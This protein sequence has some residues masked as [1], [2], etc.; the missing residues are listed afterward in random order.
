MNCPFCQHVDTKVNDSR[1]DSGGRSIRRRREC[2]ACGRRWRTLERI[3]DEMPLV[4]K[5]NQTYQ[6]FNR[7]KLLTSMTVSCGKRP[8]SISQIE[9]AAAEIEWGILESGCESVS[10]T[11]LGEMVMHHLRMLDEI[12]Y[13]RYAS[14]YRRFSDVGELIAEMKDLV[15]SAAAAHTTP[16][17]ESVADSSP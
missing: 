1:P 7:A 16:T 5:R 15:Q 10:T 17:P 11:K 2:L 12:A 9:T 4:I 3:E 14:V 8:V 6:P 13:V